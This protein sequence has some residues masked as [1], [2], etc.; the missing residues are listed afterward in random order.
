M[1]FD[2]LDQWLA[3]QETLNPAEIELGL[4]RIDRVRELAGIPDHF[5]CPLIIVAGT[6]GKGSVMAMLEAMASAAGVHVCAYTSP[7]ISRYNERIR[8]NGREV[9]DMDL[10]AAF[11][12]IDQARGDAQL[13]YFEFGTLAALDLFARAEA[14]LVL[15]EVGLGGRLDAVNIMQPDVS[16]ITTIDIDHVDWLGDDREAIG[17]EKAGIMR[18]GKTAICGD[19]MPPQSLLDRAKQLSAKLSVLG[20]DYYVLHTATG[21][22]LDTRSSIV[23][24]DLPLPALAGDFQLDNAATAIMALI[25]VQDRLAVKPEHY[26]VGLQ[27]VAL[28]GRF[29]HLGDSPE[30]IVDVAHNSQAVAALVTQL[31]SRHCAG[32]TRVVI[33][34]LADK[35]VAEVVA[36]LKPLVD[37]WYSAGLDSVGRGMASSTLAGLI[38]HALAG[39][40]DVKLCASDTVAQACANAVRDAQADDRII[41][42]G[43]FY[44]VAAAK[45]FFSNLRLSEHFSS[46]G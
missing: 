27:S 7:H 20:R 45:Q 25:A 24:H 11:E 42:L 1:R 30:V 39:A 44:T 3:W 40:G 10:C 19:R 38:Q 35:P 9:D 15:L 14:D 28:A 23:L 18:A 32:K 43:S 41:V 16:L 31:Q 46:D 13:T 26:A 6:N 12:R 17:F 2:T 22:Q 33:A 8:I 4:E 34:M 29:E 36:L 5:D 21:W 37:V